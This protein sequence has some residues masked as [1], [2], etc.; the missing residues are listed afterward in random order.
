[1]DGSIGTVMLEVMEMVMVVGLGG[2]SKADELGRDGGMGEVGGL[3]GT[4]GMVAWLGPEGGGDAALAGSAEDGGDAGG[5]ATPPAVPR[6]THA[7]LP[8]GVGLAGAG[9][10]VGED[11]GVEAAEEGA[12]QR[13][14][15]G[16]VH[17]RLPRALGQHGGEAEPAAA[18]QRHLAGG[19]VAPQAGPV[20]P[21]RLP[22]QQRPHPHRHPHRRPLRRHGGAAPPRRAAMASGGSARPRGG[23]EGGEA[24]RLGPAGTGHGEPRRGDGPGGSGV[25]GA[26][27]GTRARCGGGAGAPEGLRRC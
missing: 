9:L 7:G 24:G 12:Q 5:T 6:L 26:G 22:G 19:G 15:A 21:Q 20:S 18:A 14:D 1:M 27:D 11:G 25:A 23:G 8:D 17:G 3:G 4:A 16:P 10:P 2:E 13:L